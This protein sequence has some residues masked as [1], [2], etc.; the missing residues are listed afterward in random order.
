M[1]LLLYCAAAMMFPM[2]P[3]LSVGLCAAGYAWNRVFPA[4]Y[5][6]L[7]VAMFWLAIAG[8]V[9]GFLERG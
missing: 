2:A 9:A 8:I 5:Q 1:T 7:E 6:W 4:D 3:V